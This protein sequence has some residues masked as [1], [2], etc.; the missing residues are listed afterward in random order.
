MHLG[1]VKA[2]ESLVGVFLL[3]V[4]V[5]PLRPVDLDVLILGSALDHPGPEGSISIFLFDDEEKVES[6]FV[7]LG[8]FGVDLLEELELE[9]I[10][11]V[12]DQS[13][14][15]EVGVGEIDFFF[16]DVHKGHLE[17]DLVLALSPLYQRMKPML[18]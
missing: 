4:F 17:E 10:L 2:A 7:P 3:L 6:G 8:G 15:F 5:N 18:V 9:G 1:R 14:E 12:S 11:F 13:V 16:L